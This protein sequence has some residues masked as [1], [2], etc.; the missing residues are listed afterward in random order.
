MR[1]RLRFL[2]HGIAAL[3]LVSGARS[4]TFRDPMRPPGS[5]PAAAH[6]AKS[7]TL[8]LEGVISG[9]VRVAIVNG[10]LVQAGDEIAGARIVEVLA[11][12]VRYARAG[13]IQ[14][15]MLPGVQALATVR[16]AHLSKATKP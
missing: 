11:G 6:A 12:G 14:T 9:A 16:V 3:L 8:K 1:R 15:L 5:A 7:T 2:Q 10:R 13:H 4:Q